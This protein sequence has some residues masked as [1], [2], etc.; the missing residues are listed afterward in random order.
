MRL[1]DLLKLAHEVA[2]DTNEETIGA[3][4]LATA[5]SSLLTAE[6]C[7]WERPRVCEAPWAGLIQVPDWGGPTSPPVSPADARVMAVMLFR[8]A[9]ESEGK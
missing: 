4:E 2:A 5:I 3:I 9:D 1:D 7:G 6:T 8:A